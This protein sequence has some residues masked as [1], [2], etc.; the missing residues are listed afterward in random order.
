L[1]ARRA[2]VPLRQFHFL[3]FYILVGNPAKE[4][5]CVERCW[6]STAQARRS[7]TFIVV[8]T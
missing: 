6:P 8:R 3:T 1:L 5:R 4:V 7:E 2:Y